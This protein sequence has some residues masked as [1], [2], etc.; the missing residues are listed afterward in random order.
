MTMR[1]EKWLGILNDFFLADRNNFLLA[2]DKLKVKHSFT[3]IL[4]IDINGEVAEIF[5]NRS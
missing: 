2:V 3:R 4:L 5:S 1:G